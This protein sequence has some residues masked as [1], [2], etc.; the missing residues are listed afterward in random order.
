MT[1]LIRL[2]VMQ[3]EGNN[4]SRNIRNLTPPGTI[5]FLRREMMH[6]ELMVTNGNKTHAQF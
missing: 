6:M 2:L 3:W 4:S 5:I 1:V